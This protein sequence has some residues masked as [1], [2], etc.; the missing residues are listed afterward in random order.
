MLDTPSLPASA[1]LLPQARTEN[2]P[3]ASRLLPAR[4]RRGLLALYE[5][6]RLVDDVGDEFAGDRPAALDALD[7][8]IHRIYD[9]TPQIPTI[10]RLAPVVQEAGIP[11][12]PL[13]ALVA[14]N[15]QD[16]T[17]ARY[18]TYDDLLGY[19]RLSANPVGHLVLHVFDA[20]TPE[21]LPLSDHVCTALQVLEHV[22][23]VVEDRQRDRVYLPQ[24]DLDRFG[25]DDAALTTSPTP[26]ELR[27]VLA[28]ETARAAELLDAG[29]PLVATLRG[30]ARVAVAGFVAGGRATVDALRAHAFDVSSGG[31]RPRPARIA[32]HLATTAVRAR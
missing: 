20:A 26:P 19:C 9:G 13:H 23:D 28:R 1:D 27:R 8:D 31:P 14:A 24:E 4:R 18:A 17:V 30:A 15:R 16:Q 25:V 3:V 10:R 22:Q 29:A 21:R 2:F 32:R 11:A 5:F 6:A 12:A 7:A